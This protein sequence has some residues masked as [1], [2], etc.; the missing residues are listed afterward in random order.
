MSILEVL[1]KELIIFDGAMGTMLQARGL[2]DGIPETLCMTKP[3]AITAIHSAYAAAGADVVT[4]C[5][6]G[7]NALK[8]AG[9][10]YSPAQIVAAGVAC[11]RASGAKYVALDIGPL[12]KLL[13]PF[14]DISFEQAVELFSEQI[15]AGAGAGADLILIETMSSL[16]EAKAA[17]LAAK[18]ACGLPV[19][20]TMSFESDGRSFMGCDPLSAAI[21]LEGLGVDALGANCSLGP[22][23]LRPVI[24]EMLRV[25]G[26]PVMVQPNA[27]MPQMQ[28]GKAVYNMLPG[29][30]VEEISG[31]V[32]AGAAV[33]GGCCGTT[34]DFISALKSELGGRQVAA[35]KREAAGKR[36]ACACGT[37]ALFF[38]RRS[39]VIGERLN[40]TGKKRLQE[41]LRSGDM[42]YLLAEAAAQADAGC[43]IINLNAGLPDIDEPAMLARV[44]KEVQ[45]LCQLPL[46]LDSANPAAL[47][48]A[49]RVYNGKPIINSVNGSQ[50]VMDKVFPIAKKYGA[51]VVCL[52][53]DEDGI[54]ET[55]EGRVAVLKRIIA[56]AAK[57][58]IAAGELIADCLALTASAQQAHV[59]ETLRAISAVR[60]MG[61]RSVLG[62]SNVSFG[63]PAREILNS[64]FLA[65]A[66]G[67]GLDAAIIDPLSKR[68]RETIDAFRVITGEDA[69]AVNYTERYSGA[70]AAPA[71][72]ATAAAAG[73][74]TN[75]ADLIRQGRREEA[76]AKTRDLLAGL[77]ALEIVDGQIIPALTKMGE[78]FERGEI[79]LPQ[80]M[81]AA[82]AAQG[83]FNVVRDYLAN[84]R[85]PGASAVRGKVLL[86]TVRGDVHDIGKNIVRLLLENYGYDVLDMGKDVPPQDIVAAAKSQGIRLIGL[87]ALM[88]TTVA[89]MKETVAALRE[90]GHDCRVMVGGAVIDPRYA[91]F[92][93]ADMY[94]KDAMEGVAMTKEFFKNAA[95][96]P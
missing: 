38:D 85:D 20:C 68:Y 36:G 61:M 80:L 41:A 35:G 62:V 26:V 33:I 73:G 25:S 2:G 24:E 92:V 65:A 57:H 71:V 86:A 58:G 67:A 7:A 27:G 31:M 18:E 54:P 77:P 88:T 70:A 10:G 96:R 91:D 43:H 78:R 89:S 16:Y 34:P 29:Q 56:E 64:T 76:S 60:A 53:L 37:G 40:P 75:L 19:F 81:Q 63:L 95:A 87:S 69:N 84:S 32:Q 90:A 49:A 66:L 30:F 14:G 74:E 17:V 42:S 11:A 23:L 55:A 94:A 6:F 13:E 5:T 93:G 47:A 48:A 12:G 82:Q 1:G 51:L 8:L 21:T 52:A 59:A 39:I 83:G 15:K 9:T 3:D 4:T 79:F 28:D 46:M 45:G 22:A 44:T 50:A 72:S